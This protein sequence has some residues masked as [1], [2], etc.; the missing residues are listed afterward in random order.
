[1]GMTPIQVEEIAQISPPTRLESDGYLRLSYVRGGAR[2][3]VEFVG[4]R[5]VRLLYEPPNSEE[6][7]EIFSQKDGIPDADGTVTLPDDPN[8]S[9]PYPG[10]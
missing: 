2:I 10:R 5:A 8:T 7:Q 3:A 6:S 4:D 9:D 1:M